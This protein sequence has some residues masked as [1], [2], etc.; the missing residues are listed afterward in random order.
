M[1]WLSGG[2]YSISRHCSICCTCIYTNGD[3]RYTRLPQP[4]LLLSL[5]VVLLMTGI[6]NRRRSLRHAA[7]ITL[8]NAQH[9]FDL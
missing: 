1:R 4:Y 5:W 2:A 6:N 3:K 9:V 8:V 7:R